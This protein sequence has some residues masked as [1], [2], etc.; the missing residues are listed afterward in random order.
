MAYAH[1]CNCRFSAVGML[2]TISFYFLRFT[3]AVE[4]FDAFPNVEKYNNF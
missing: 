4:L 1:F 3:D 2:P